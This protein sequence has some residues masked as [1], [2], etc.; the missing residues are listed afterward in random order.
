MTAGLPE[1]KPWALGGGIAAFGDAAITGVPS[2]LA[3]MDITN[4]FLEFLKPF[5]FAHIAAVGIA[6]ALVTFNQVQKGWFD[7][8]SK[9]LAHGDKKREQ[10]LKLLEEGK[11]ETVNATVLQAHAK[12]AYGVQLPTHVLRHVLTRDDPEVVTQ[13]AF[14]AK[15]LIRLEIETEKFDYIEGKKPWE[16]LET[17]YTCVAVV[18]G[19]IGFLCCVYAVGIKELLPIGFAVDF[20]AIAWI[21]TNKSGAL[22]AAKYLIKNS[23]LPP[24]EPQKRKA[25]QTDAHQMESPKPSAS[26]DASVADEP[27]MR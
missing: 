5:P 3:T 16:H 14:S 9:R 12:R 2:F 6:V 4:Q 26:T 25:A 21:I 22:Y 18:S 1:I 11:L 7:F 15:R 8:L 10:L 20:F 24:G 17:F 19:L 23:P 27:G 13:F